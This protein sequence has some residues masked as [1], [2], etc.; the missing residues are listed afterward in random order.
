M[1]LTPEQLASVLSHLD[2]EL[3]KMRSAI[4]AMPTKPTQTEE[5]TG[6]KAM[7]ADEEKVR[8]TLSLPPATN[9]KLVAYAVLMDLSL[10]ESVDRLLTIM[11]K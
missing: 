8:F 11:L 2:K 10:S 3:I 4:A 9:K 7:P 6:P 5:L 1:N